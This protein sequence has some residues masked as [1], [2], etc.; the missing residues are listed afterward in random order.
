MAL[1]CM[2]S[3]TRKGRCPVAVQSFGMYNMCIHCIVFENERYNEGEAESP[4]GESEF[5]IASKLVG[6]LHFEKG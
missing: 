2:L 4:H 3:Q 6:F 5:C 1:A